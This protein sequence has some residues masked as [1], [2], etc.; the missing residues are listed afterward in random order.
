[1][2]G[3]WISGGRVPSRPFVLEESS[4]WIMSILQLGSHIKMVK[5]QCTILNEKAYVYAQD[6]GYTKPY[7]SDWSGVTPADMIEQWNEKSP[8]STGV[9]RVRQLAAEIAP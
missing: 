7:W 3:A 1:M 8:V 9:Y 4:S 6:A 2:A 5:L